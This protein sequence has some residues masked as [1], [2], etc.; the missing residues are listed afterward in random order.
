MTSATLAGLLDWLIEQG[1]E[2]RP[3]GAVVDGTCERLNRAGVPIL[4]A[5]FSSTT[6]HPQYESVGHLWQREQTP[7]FKGYRHGSDDEEAWQQS[8]LKV[9]LEGRLP[10]FRRR[11]DTA[12]AIAEFP[13]FAEFAA[14]GATDY[15][16]MC[17]PFGF[18]R[19][20]TALDDEGVLNSWLT[21][22]PG[23]FTEAQIDLLIRLQRPLCLAVRPSVLLDIGRTVCDVY[24]GDDA[25]RRVLNGS[26]RRGDV[27]SLEAAILFA[28]L[29]G[30]TALSDRLPAAVLLPML[31]DYLEAMAEAVLD[32]GGQVLKFL[33]DGLLATFDL[34]RGELP[35]VGAAAL[36][37]A[38]DALDRVGALN[39]AAR[40]AGRAA[41]DLDVALH[42]GE[43]LYGNVGCERRLDFTVIG[44]AVNE[45]ARMEALCA[46]E[47]CA[48]VASR[49]FVAATG[50]PERFRSLGRH[51]L[52]GLADP[53]ELYTTVER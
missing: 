27:S 10:R 13:V 39:D 26:I 36:A 5:H 49:A 34:S 41:M 15:L 44:P 33:G 47:G 7:V 50:R 23:G 28:D 30:F 21:D 25:G 19:A 43:V 42:V 8:P 24:L 53:R 38:E 12:A 22:Q 18:G 9:V 14:L 4:R 2:G 16:A 45:A 40:A 48:L 11:L 46:A 6:L 51:A 29:R 1:L 20:A 35:A 32:H 17:T 52:R 3:V 31:D 37:A